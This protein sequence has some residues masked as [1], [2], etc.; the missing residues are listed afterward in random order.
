M[1]LAW[2]HVTSTMDEAVHAGHRRGSRQFR[3][4]T[5][6]MFASGLATFT[7]LYCVQALFPAIAADFHL[8]PATVSLVLSVSTLTL[9]IGVIP[10]T[11]LSESLG[12]TRV[13]IA[14]LTATAV[15]GVLVPF[16]PNLTLLLVMRALQGFALAGLQATAMSYLSEELHRESLGAGM[17][18]YIAGN[19]IGGMLGRVLAGV[20][21]DFGSWRLAIG[22]VGLLA[23][24]C[25]IVFA[26]LILPSQRFAPKPLR[27]RPLIGSIGTA[28]RDHGLLRL[29]LAGF[30]AMGAFVTVY[31]YLGFRL[32][33]APF[34]LPHAV[35]SLLFVV[36]IA[37]SAASTIAGRLVDRF[38]RPR[39]L[40]S[41]AICTIAGIVLLAFGN[42]VLIIIGLVLFTGGFFATHAVAS[43]WVGARAAVLAVPG[44]AIYL[45]CY[46]L[47]SSIGGTLGGVWFADSGWGGVTGYIGVLF[48]LVVLLGLTLIGLKPLR[49][50]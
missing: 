13:M 20:V 8:S 35:V 34:H 27:V 50:S 3:R 29:Y 38:G 37:G 5:I 48:G 23:V 17:G 36:Y 41:M 21:V 42:L 32:L 22:A 10:L 49:R 30:L 9:A 6:A 28:L 33:R 43:G 2:S 44:A 26:L 40:W 46:Y 11:T 25:T 12:R 19:G 15:L 7:V 16:A 18:L 14:S 1:R 31:N 4:I 24:A 45:F 39:M 47:G